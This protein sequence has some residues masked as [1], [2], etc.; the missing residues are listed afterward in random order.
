MDKICVVID[1]E[2]FQIKSRGG[3]YT[4]ELGYCDWQRHHIGSKHYQTSGCLMDLPMRDR[5]TCE[6]VTKHI[7]GLSYTARPW[8]NAR[9]PRDLHNDVR[10]LYEQHRTPH[11]YLVGYKG[12]HVEKDLL[13][14]LNIP[15]HNLEEDGCP[16]FLDMELLIGVWG[17]GNHQKPSIHHCPVIECVHFVNWMRKESGLSF[18][19]ANKYPLD[20]VFF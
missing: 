7:H 16:R 5:K 17:C 15:S 10:A 20:F 1:L 11:R 2:G 18:Q 9:P 3:F 4:R 14:S 19:T 8:E 12:G 6:Y 13:D